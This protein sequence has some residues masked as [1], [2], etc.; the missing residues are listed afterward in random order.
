MRETIFY[1]TLHGDHAHS[2]YYCANTQ[3]AI[4]S[5]DPTRIP[6]AELGSYNACALC[7]SFG[8]AHEVDTARTATA[9]PVKTL[10]TNSGVVNPRRMMS[11]CTDCGKEGT[12]NRRT[13][14]L[15]A[16]EAPEA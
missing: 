12:V 9:K 2:S 10:C 16:H 13:G 4:S 7:C 11:T 15:R 5:G 8:Q 6:A 1:R 14:S 3:R